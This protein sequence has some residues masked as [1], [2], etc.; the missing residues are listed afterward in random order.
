MKK[1]KILYYDI[2]TSHAM[3][4]SFGLFPDYISHDN[5]LLDWYLF[6]AAWQWEGQKTISA[7]ALTDDPKRFAKDKHDDYHVVKTLHAVLEQADF[8][9]AHNGDK[10]DLKKFNTRVIKHGLKPLP[11]F[12]QIDTLKIAKRNF[13]FTS[14][15]LD[16]LGTFLGV[17][18]KIH[19][20]PGLWVRAWLGEKKAIKEMKTY[21]KGDIVLLRD[22]YKKLEPYDKHSQMNL[23]L[24]TGESGCPQCGSQKAQARGYSV[25]RVSRYKRFQCQDCGKWYQA[26]AA[27]KDTKVE[28][29]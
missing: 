5:I 1:P 2:E 8:V 28:V 24:F 17:G 4:L 16:Y 6:S 26:R 10:F 18:K 12:K 21:N 15:R 3:L 23:G 13:C 20:E 9:V 25:T 11:P 29:K 14:N 22:V 27:D 7:V 19:T